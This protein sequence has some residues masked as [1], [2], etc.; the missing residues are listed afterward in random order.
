M[1]K[2]LRAGIAKVQMEGGT[3]TATWL[4]PETADAPNTE[5]IELEYDPGWFQVTTVV[6]GASAGAWFIAPGNI[7]KNGVTISNG[8][9]LDVSLYRVMALCK[10]ADVG[11]F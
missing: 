4:D 11:I 1:S 7:T 8:N 9:V 10:I 5:T 2:R 6:A 3:G